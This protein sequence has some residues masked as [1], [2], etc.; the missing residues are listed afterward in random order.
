[1]RT[2]LNFDDDVAAELAARARVEHR[3]LSRVAND[4]IRAGLTVGHAHA[5]RTPYEPPTFDTGR[6]FVDVTDVAAA[7]EVLDG[8]G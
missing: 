7:L 4:L 1:M 5:R 8:D 2:T 3:S 6:P